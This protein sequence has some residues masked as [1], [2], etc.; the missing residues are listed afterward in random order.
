MDCKRSEY[1]REK[2]CEQLFLSERAP[3]ERKRGYY[4]EVFNLEE[5]KKRVIESNR[6]SQREWQESIA[7][8]RAV[9]I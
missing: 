4:Q 3:M 1:E 9:K 2:R 5:M 7:E 8:K 6:R